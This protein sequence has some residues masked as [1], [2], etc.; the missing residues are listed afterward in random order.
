MKI[1]VLTSSRADYGIYLPLLKKLKLDDF[2][3][4]EIIAFGS[5]LSK[6]HGFTITEIESDLWNGIHK[7]SSI[8]TNDDEQSTVTAYGLTALKFA[9]FWDSNKFDL[10][11]CLGDRFEMN[12]AVQAGIPFNVKFAHFHGGETTTGAI[13]N[14]YRHQITLASVLHFTATR[15]YSAKV[16]EL[17]GS[18]TNIH[19]VGSLSLDGIQKFQPME[20]ERFYQKFEIP[21]EDFALVTLHPDTKNLES[22][23]YY[24]LE[25][26]KALR[27]LTNK[28][29]IVLTMPNVDTLGSVYR[30]EFEI[31]RR[32][33]SSRVLCI[34][35]LGK[36]NY[37]NALFYSK[38]IIGNSSSGII[39][40]ASFGKIVINIGDRQKG[41]VQSGNVVD[42]AFRSDEILKAVDKSLINEFKGRNLYVKRNTVKNVI[43]VLK[44]FYEVI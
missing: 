30:S 43:K 25:V 12:A 37:F 2:F 29:F 33:Y 22:N 41:R 39:E 17:T 1:G 24:A 19:T 3:S 4:L 28:L 14:V 20:K 27:K 36:E 35:N 40:A 44:D 8:L 9:Q 38:L 21:N 5:H 15:V 7:I 13:D 34:E 26:S 16:T 23:T 42:V 10:V 6:A 18:N 32:E 11:F 31:L